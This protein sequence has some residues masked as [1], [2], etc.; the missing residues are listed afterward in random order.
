MTEERNRL[1]MVAGFV[2]FVALLG[3]AL[4]GV[5]LRVD[6]T[7]RESNVDWL[8]F[9]LFSVLLVLGE[10]QPRFWMR[11]GE[12]G[13][14]TPGWAF[15]FALVLLGSP[16][17][18][19]IVMVATSLLVDAGHDKGAL[20]IVFNVS[21]IAAALAVGGLVMHAFGVH[22]G[23]THND[24][25]PITTGIAIV[26]AGMAIFLVN[27]LLTATVICLH[28]RVGLITMMRSG[29]ILSMAV[30][31]AL[32]ALAP[33]FVIA[34]DFSMLM[35]PLLA[36]TSFLVFQ[37]AR[38]AL[39]REHE[40]SH[41]PLTMLLNRRAFDERLAIALDAT[42]EDRHTLVL[43]MD[44]DRFK[45]IND[46]LGHVVGDRLLRSF[47]ERLE[48]I[49]PPTASASRLGGDEFAVVMPAIKN[50]DEARAVVDDLYGRLSKN[51]DLS[52]FP[53]S[54]AVSI[55][56][57]MA[58]MHGESASSLI[59]AA[60]LAMYRAKQFSSGIEFASVNDNAHD[61]GRVG[62]L[63]DLSA[64]IGTDQIVAHYQPM[65]RLSDGTIESVEALI[66]WT[67]PEF[68]PIAP[69][70]FI[71]M[72]EQTDLIGPL[73]DSILE[74]AIHDLLTLGP[75]MPKL[76]LNVAARNLQDRQFATR[77]IDVMRDLGFPP[78]RL[79]IEITERDIVTNSERSA[80]ALA[81][82]RDHGVRI[83]IDDFGTGYASFLTLRELR[84][85]RLKIDQQFTSN[86][87][88]SRADELI[89]TKVIEIAHSLGL[90]VVAEGVESD[91]VW[92]R[93]G[94][95]GCDVAQGFA[96]AR[97]MALA[98]LTRW[99]EASNNA[100]RP[101]EEARPVA[102]VMVEGGRGRREVLAS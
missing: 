63:A 14:V 102:R 60:D 35:L 90:D 89:V 5:L 61:F 92:R 49:L 41:D 100:V 30:D 20:K 25:L 8:A 16:S 77:V 47:A 39:Q 13:E 19:V 75:N 18:A 4:F 7:D 79:E 97:P 56:A 32:L 94:Q 70:D 43:V 15:A 1:R 88:E 6:L 93:L 73:T 24:H 21:Q 58:P 45:D 65:V 84:A 78:D 69:G 26:A 3:T 48:R 29:F 28:Q 83:A 11:F 91:D 68:G 85:D 55:G 86:M 9:G 62:L 66:R 10:T 22:D 96:I 54:A 31:G 34:I 80:L 50:L 2:G 23:I 33:V 37:S 44:L 57:A 81:R 53:L 67:H 99:V 27:G 40:A 101:A 98:D 87:F 17:G 64:A 36:V 72:T 59:A 74:I 42:A 51:H 71:A 76:C 95:L 52:G 82:L 46:R 38:T 12:G